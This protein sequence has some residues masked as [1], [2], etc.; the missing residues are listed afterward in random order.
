MADRVGRDTQRALGDAYRSH[1]DRIY[2]S[3]YR[4]VGSTAAAADLT[5]DAF[6]RALEQL[7]NFRGDAAL[8]TWISRIAV[9][10]AIRHLRRERRM[11]VADAATLAALERPTLA[12][13]ALPEALDLDHAITALP[14]ALRLVFVLR[15]VEGYSYAEIAVMLDIDEAT[16]RQRLHRARVQLAAALSEAGRG[17]A[18]R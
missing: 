13:P 10:L 6:L 9:N 1:R 16:C 2:T 12:A 5:H 7:P 3:V 15:A 14:D 11:V 8:G 4:I 18:R 17:G